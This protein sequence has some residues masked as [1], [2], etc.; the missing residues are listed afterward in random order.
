M[1]GFTRDIGVEPDD[2]NLAVSL[3]FVT[4]VTLQPASAAM[5]RWL[6]A[7]NWIPII[8]MGWG[9][10]TIAQAW[11]NN[12]ASL[13]TIRLLIGAF[14]SGFYP[15]AVAYLSTWYTSFDLAVRIALFY[16]QYAVAGAF[17][18]SIAY[19]VFQI[20]GGTL[21]NWQ[22]LFIIEGAATC[23]VAA[24]AWFWLPT[25]PQ[26][27]WFLNRENRKLVVNRIRRETA[28]Y[29]QHDDEDNGLGKGRLTKRDWIETA[30]DWKLW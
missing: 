11:T 20:K 17:G 30:K 18:G 12:K 13:I 29:V 27:A 8:M 24:V 7:K 1:A 10:C 6:G 16:G 23:V 19:G 2:L 28:M 22:W 3:F 25:G 26:S 5:G 9:A 15:T 21:H 4:F 14:E